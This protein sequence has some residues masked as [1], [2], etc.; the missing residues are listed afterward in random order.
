MGQDPQQ[1]FEYYQKQNLLPAIKMAMIED[2]LL[3]KLLND[4]N[5]KS[6]EETKEKK[7]YELHTFVIEKSGRGERS[8]G[9]L[10]EASQRSYH[11]VERSYRRCRRLLRRRARLFL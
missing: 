2:R 10:F 9:H 5:E 7:K 1:T 6:K 4:K 11:H 3:T 8:Y